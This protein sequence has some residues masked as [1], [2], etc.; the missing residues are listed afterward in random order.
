MNVVLIPF[1]R[2]NLSFRSIFLGPGGIWNDRRHMILTTNSEHLI[3]VAA[4]VTKVHHTHHAI[5]LLISSALCLQSFSYQN[6]LPALP[7]G[8]GCET[9]TP[10]LHSK[11]LNCTSSKTIAF[12]VSSIMHS[13][14]LCLLCSLKS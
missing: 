12:V 10:F 3:I 8:D 7:E 2:T 9:I 6:Y 14:L 5:R 11:L 13:F 4:S 1:K